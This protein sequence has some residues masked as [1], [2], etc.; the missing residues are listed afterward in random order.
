MLK[1]VFEKFEILNLN[2]KENN[3]DNE[4]KQSQSTVKNANLIV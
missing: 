2:K 1:N 4:S 3:F